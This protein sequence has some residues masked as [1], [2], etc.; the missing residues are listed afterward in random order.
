LNTLPYLIGH[1][2]HQYEV[3]RGWGNLDPELYPVADCHEMVID[4]AG[5]IFLLTNEI[6]NNILIYN[7]KGKLVGSWGTTYPGA[8]GLSIAE[9]NDTEFLLITDIV[10]HQVIKTRLDGTELLILDYPKEIDAYQ[11]AEQ[12][13][14]TETA[15]AANGDIYVTDG[16]GLQFVIQYNNKGGYIRH[17][18][19]FGDANDKFDCVHGIAIDNRDVANPTLVITSRNQNAFKRF[20]LN[21]RYVETISLPGSFVCRPVIK[22]KFLY[23]AVF[24]SGSNTNFGSGYIIILDEHDKVVSA[25]GGSAPEYVNNMLQPQYQSNYAFIHPHDVCIDNDDNIIVCQWKSNKT[26]PIKLKKV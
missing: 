9:E 2:A 24:R 20:T 6:R 21:G 14:P 17:W 11:S 26:Y 8:H 15:V 4:K 25:P 19:G 7:N 22:G 3:L 18:G 1:N 12:F 10:R 23:A 5:R 13:N 16:Y